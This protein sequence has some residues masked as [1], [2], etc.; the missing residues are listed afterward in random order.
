MSTKEK[1]LKAA[2]YIRV[3]TTYQIDK[4]SLPFQRQELINYAKYALGIDDVEIFEDAGYSGKN[5]ERPAY[6]DMMSRI[7][8]KEFT[9]LM[10][11]KID[12]ISR[13]LLDF[14]AMYEELKKYDVIFISKNE[15][16]DT[17]SA[18]GE[19]MLKII[20]VFAELER[21]LTS[22]RVKGVMLSRAE[23][24]LWNG[25]TVPLGYIW[26]SR[27]KKGED[28]VTFPV[29]NSEEAKLVQYI[30]DLYEEL[31]STNKVAIKLNEDKVK[32]KRDNPWYA[33]TINEIISNPFY[34][35]TYRYN[36]RKQKSGPF[37]DPSEWIVLENNHPGIIDKDQWERCNEILAK[38]R[39][40]DKSEFI[41]KY[42]H[43]F[44][45]LFVCGVCGDSFTAHKD[46]KRKDGFHPS[47]YICGSVSKHG[48]CGNGLAS[49]IKHGPF[50]FKYIS[51]MLKARKSLTAL[52][53]IQDLQAMLLHG[54][55]FDGIT[56]IETNGLIQTYDTIINSPKPSHLSIVKPNSPKM[57]IKSELELMQTEKKK[58]ERA[59]ER[60]NNLY[61][62]SDSALPEKDFI[63]NRK[64]ITDEID[65]I[66]NQIRDMNKKDN[67]NDSLSFMSDVSLFYFNRLMPD[68]NNIDFRKMVGLVGEK[69]LNT[70]LRSII[71]SIEILHGSITA[72]T[73]TNGTVHK[74]IYKDIL[75][76]SNK[77]RVL[78]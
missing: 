50:I 16:F 27:P 11:W 31:H 28:K 14:S 19:A 29:V 36:L 10:V 59:L 25:A 63:M 56:A 62:Y 44:S 30:Y 1:M 48:T 33:K 71:S 21:K 32:S 73:F 76:P 60:L 65:K 55:I 4:D 49:D 45:K 64:K 35:G 40:G 17:S 39:K 43:V 13:N 74:F 6:Q 70:F 51:N 67:G 2:L 52:N 77:K 54:E 15:Q 42:N 61:L 68:E 46:R 34:I 3:S 66:N 38:N 7:R 53:S 26:D 47:T 41:Q 22:E 20:L 9:H 37:R 23:K 8:K 58:Q 24:G 57:V 12:R 69:E 78:N 18:M 72:I 5:T 75:K